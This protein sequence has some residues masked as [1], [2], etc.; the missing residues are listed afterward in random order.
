MRSART[1]ILGGVAGIVLLA[2]VAWATPPDRDP[3]RGDPPCD[4]G[5]AGDHARS[6]RQQ[7]DR[8]RHAD[9]SDDFLTIVVPRPSVPP[10]NIEVPPPPVVDPPDVTIVIPSP[11]PIPDEITI[12][13]PPV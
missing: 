10:V 3:P 11:P 9:D 4:R 6:C 5:S 8:G 12:E 7:D 2:G 1:P 13:L